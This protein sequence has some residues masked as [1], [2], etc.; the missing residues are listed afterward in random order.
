MTAQS[1][2]VL[3]VAE[4]R[5]LLRRLSRSLGAFGYSV[6]EA[7][8]HQQALVAVDAGTVDMMIVDGDPD[9]RA[10]LDFCGTV[11]GRVHPGHVHTFLSVSEPS[12][13]RLKE[14]LEAGVDDFLTKPIVYGELLARLRAGA[15]MS[16]FERRIAQQSRV[17]PLTNLPSRGAFFDRLRGE[18]A[19]ARGMLRPELCVLVDIDFLERFNRVYGRAAGDLA[20]QAVAEKLGERRHD[21]D[22]LASFGAGRFALWIGEK[23]EEEVAAWANETAEAMAAIEIP[24]QEESLRLTV[25]FG[26]AGFQE[27]D[28]TPD[29]IIERAEDALVEAKCSGRNAVVCHGLYDRDAAHWAD[30]AT[31]GKLFEST[32]ARDVMTPCTLVLRRDESAARAAELLMQTQLEGLPV[33]DTDGKLAGFVFL[34]TVL[35]GPSQQELGAMSVGEVTADDVPIYD[36][37]TDF[38]TMM[39]FFTNDSRSLIGIAHKGRPAGFVTP[40]SLAALS[41]PLTAESFQPAGAYASESS[42]LA[43]SDLCPLDDVAA[44]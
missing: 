12:A 25:S 11:D 34:D 29:V 26:I 9:I 3:V 32:V 18:L 1:L 5:H 2:T 8:D 4:D 10:A 17:D 14:A 15:R 20:I 23:S 24:W 13:G 41:M 43:V 36:E 33:V 37:E 28:H 38:A 40:N 22:L 35:D 44:P 6:F 21:S 16:E 19:R 39:D 7:A 27:G 42:Y 31:P 30:I